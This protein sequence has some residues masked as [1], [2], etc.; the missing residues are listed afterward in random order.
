MIYSYSRLA[1]YRGEY[2]CP[3]KFYLKYVR[4]IPEPVTAALTLGKS[5]H[6]VIGAHIQTQAGLY[7]LCQA[8]GAA[9]EI[10][11]DEL[12]R[13]VDRKPVR[14]A[15]EKGGT[16]EEHF[17][18]PLGDGLISPTL[19]GYIDYHRVEDRVILVDWKTNHTPYG[20]SDTHQLGLYAAY[21]S[22]KYSLPVEGSLVFLR[23]GETK[24]KIYEA[25]D[26]KESLE[27]AEETAL[28]IEALLVKNDPRVFVPCPGKACEYCAYAAQCPE[29][30]TLTA[31]VKLEDAERA[32]AE[33]LR[34][35]AK[36]KQLKEMLRNWVETHG[37]V[38]VNGKEFLIQETFYWKW[39]E[40]AFDSAVSLML[41]QGF[42]PFK[43]LRLTAESLKKL[44]WDENTVASLGAQ[45]VVSHRF[46]SRKA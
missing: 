38:R 28:E 25:A 17:E 22:E 6:A 40:K 41:E 5:A 29:G 37:P 43:V 12:Y 19:Q 39:P 16:V 33:I 13:L 36:T 23:T 46:D 9:N 15:A 35:E 31:I 8:V 30:V 1:T 14:D 21:L 24:T 45:K 18:V 44:G 2:G 4:E 34:L 3:W 10:D 7:P 26:I 27:W 32:A 20:P 42:D 11:P